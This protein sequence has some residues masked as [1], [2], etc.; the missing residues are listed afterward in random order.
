MNHRTIDR[1]HPFMYKYKTGYFIFIP[2]NFVNTEKSDKNEEAI[3][4]CF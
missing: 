2:N 4:F 1:L 3:S